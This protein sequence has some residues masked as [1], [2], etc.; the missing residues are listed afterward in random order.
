MPT[1]HHGSQPL[2]Y[3]D[4]G[5]D[6]PVVVFSHS[7]GMNGAMFVSSSMLFGASIVASPGTSAPMAAALPKQ[8]L[9]PGIRRMIVWRCST[10]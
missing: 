1:F 3:D 2:C 8:A 7:F 4:T 9:R 10:I 6:G 5:G